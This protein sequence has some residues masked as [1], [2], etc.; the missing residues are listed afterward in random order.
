[1]TSPDMGLDELVTND[2]R[3]DKLMRTIPKTPA[4]LHIIQIIV[5]RDEKPTLKE[6]VNIIS[7]NIDQLG[8]KDVLGKKMDDGSAT[9]LEVTNSAYIKGKA[10]NGGHT[11]F[12]PY[13]TGS[14]RKGT[15]I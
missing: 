4:G 11:R 12:N 10:V 13:K 5:S 9:P 8:N 7:R 3:V 2:I 15:L 6:V 14:G 1:M